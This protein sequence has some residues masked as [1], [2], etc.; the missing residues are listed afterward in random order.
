MDK[1]IVTIKQLADIVDYCV[2]M[3]LM[4]QNCYDKD[5]TPNVEEAI[6]LNQ[7]RTTIMRDKII[8][9]QINED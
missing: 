8:L 4:G 3:T 1:Y 5:W 2:H 6:G 9:E 7:T